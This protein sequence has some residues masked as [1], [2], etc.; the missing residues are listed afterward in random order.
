MGPYA[1]GTKRHRGA[2]V[3]TSLASLVIFAVLAEGM[4]ITKAA[5]ELKID[6]TRGKVEPMPVA[7]TNFLGRSPRV[8]SI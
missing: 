1:R 4:W 2:V 8:K 3:L 5:A 7:I 6:I